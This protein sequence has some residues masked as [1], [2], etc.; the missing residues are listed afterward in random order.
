[1]NGFTSFRVLQICLLFLVLP[2]TACV[3][4]SDDGGSSKPAT[5]FGTWNGVVIDTYYCEAGPESMQID[6][7]ESNVS[8]AVNSISMGT[9]TL[10]EDGPTYHH[11]IVID[12][13]G[14]MLHGRIMFN[15]N[16]RYALVVL[17]NN[18]GGNTGYVGLL[19]KTS[20]ADTV[21]LDSDVVANW[22]GTSLQIDNNFDFLAS[23][24]SNIAITNTMSGLQLSGNDGLLAIGGTAP[25][26][27]LDSANAKSGLFVS[28]D[29]TVNSVAWGSG[30]K[31]ALYI[32]SWDKK[33]MA[34]GFIDGTCNYSLFSNTDLQKF[35]LW[36][37]KP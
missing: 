37:K 10:T 18:V 33:A 31:N 20:P 22:G 13:N 12:N 24:D 11:K 16:Y 5:K 30:S 1:M 29:L 2:I 27:V 14:S 6:I 34:A 15:P 21:F 8:I 26:I 23:D 17:T 32:E 36:T 7:T 25:N 3:N 9:V 19:Q 28:G 4:T 35:F